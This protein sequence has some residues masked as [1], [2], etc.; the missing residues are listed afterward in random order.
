M[1]EMT[2]PIGAGNPVGVVATSKLFAPRR[3]NCRPRI[4]AMLLAKYCDESL[5]SNWCPIISIAFGN[6]GLFR[7]L[8]LAEVAV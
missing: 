6:R 3:G 4:S 1:I 7:S 8:P 2:G 5:S